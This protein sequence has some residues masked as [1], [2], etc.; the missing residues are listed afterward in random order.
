MI[1][2]SEKRF[3]TSNLLQVG[4]WTPNHRA[5]QNRG[6]VGGDAE[7]ASMTDA[8]FAHYAGNDTATLVTNLTSV[9]A[10]YPVTSPNLSSSQVVTLFNDVLLGEGNPNPDSPLA[11][12]ILANYEKFLSDHN[13]Q[14]GTTVTASNFSG[15]L[16]GLAILSLYYNSDTA[17]NGTKKLLPPTGHLVPDLNQNNFNRPDAWFQIRY[18]SNGG[19]NAL[20]TTDPAGQGFNG[21]ADRRYLE[22]AFFG[23]YG[24]GVT[25]PSLDYATKIY[26]ELSKNTN[27]TKASN[28]TGE[29]TNREF[30]IDYENRYSGEIAV[31]NDTVLSGPDSL[32]AFETGA[33]VTQL[34][35]LTVE[36]LEDE[37]QSAFNP[38]WEQYLGDATLNPFAAVYASSNT[39]DPLDLQVALA[40]GGSDLVA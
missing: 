25:T 39:V 10:S 3:F 6:D 33:S 34:T 7:R 12:S 22:S 14:T 16:E 24:S 27:G 28:P 38:L 26:A 19:Y 9:M 31:G 29:L 1:C 40:K 17:N 36:T 2:S 23:L 30:A 37:L 13:I 5:T 15:S 8:I 20:T 11:T 21:T 32:Q 4:N 35:S 18:G